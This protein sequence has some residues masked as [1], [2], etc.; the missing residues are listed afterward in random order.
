MS[1]PMYMYNVFW[2]RLNYR[3][4]VFTTHLFRNYLYIHPN[5]FVLVG[6]QPKFLNMFKLLT[7][8]YV[9]L[10]CIF[11]ECGSGSWVSVH[12]VLLVSTSWSDFR[13]VKSEV[14]NLYG[15]RTDVIRGKYV[16]KDRNT[17]LIHIKLQLNS[18]L[19]QLSYTTLQMLNMW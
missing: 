13:Y 19:L 14:Y 2:P 10:I 6:E 18:K 7:T 15:P 11:R 5:P 1:N 16:V 9:S 17:S 12:R 3:P 4:I 8:S